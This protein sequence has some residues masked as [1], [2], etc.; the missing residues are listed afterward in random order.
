MSVCK[1]QKLT[2][3]FNNRLSRWTS[4]SHPGWVVTYEK[5]AK[6]FEKVPKS[7]HGGKKRQKCIPIWGGGGWDTIE[8]TGGGWFGT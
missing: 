1:K 3:T 2:W 6:F 5:K 8:T 4:G 7:C